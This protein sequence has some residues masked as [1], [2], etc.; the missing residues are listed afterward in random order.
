MTPFF[1]SISYMLFKCD[2]WRGEINIQNISD[3][4]FTEHIFM[5]AYGI[6]GTFSLKSALLK[7][8][9]YSELFWSAFGLNTDQNNSEYGLFLRSGSHKWIELFY[10]KLRK[11]Y[12]TH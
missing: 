10:Q 5:S 7:E 6:G 11:L 3:D 9:P 2:S 8:C 4:H 12:L 1:T